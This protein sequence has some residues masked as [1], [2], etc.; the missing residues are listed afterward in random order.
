MAVYQAQKRMLGFQF[1]P[2]SI[3]TVQGSQLLKQSIDFL[4]QGVSNHE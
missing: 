4:T 3:L 2:E 1:H